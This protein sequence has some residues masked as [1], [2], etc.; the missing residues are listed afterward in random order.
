MPK[1]HRVLVRYRLPTSDQWSGLHW[2]DIERTESNEMRVRVASAVQGERM[3]R[4]DKFED[5]A[6]EHAKKL[7][8]I[9]FPGPDETPGGCPLR[10]RS[11]E[12][13]SYCLVFTAN[14]M[15]RIDFR[16]PLNICLPH[17]Q[18]WVEGR[19]FN[20]QNTISLSSCFTEAEIAHDKRLGMRI[21]AD[22]YDLLVYPSEL[23]LDLERQYRASDITAV[24]QH[25]EV[26]HKVQTAVVDPSHDQTNRYW[27][28]TERRE[29][30]AIDMASVESALESNDRMLLHDTVCRELTGVKNNCNSPEEY[31]LALYTLL[32]KD[33][34]STDFSEDLMG[35]IRL[36]RNTM[37]RSSMDL[38]RIFAQEGSTKPSLATVCQYVFA[39]V[40]QELKNQDSSLVSQ[41]SDD[42]ITRS[43]PDAYLNIYLGSSNEP[44]E[45]WQG[46]QS[47][48]STANDARYAAFLQLGELQQAQNHDRLNS[49]YSNSPVVV[50]AR[51]VS[52]GLESEQGGRQ[53]NS[54]SPNLAH[55]HPRLHSMSLFRSTR[56]QMPSEAPQVNRLLL[57]FIGAALCG[58]GFSLAFSSFFTG[59]AILAGGILCL[60]ASNLPTNHNPAAN[61]VAPSGGFGGYG[62]RLL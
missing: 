8:V 4:D 12:L 32:S 10:V 22:N 34:I 61:Y 36:F 52:V 6:P 9:D 21:S 49:A 33:E 13:E 20:P 47:G 37:L 38:N 48:I 31:Q 29:K 46:R 44:S 14:A 23:I 7:L 24:P 15:F 1:Y 45:V 5:L 19:L 3:P 41:S 35:A 50:G 28:T 56:G 59:A 60:L 18:R 55:L 27:L 11:S 39:C 53:S 17:G 57:R 51:D 43:R 30:V 40:F 42:Y 54:L 26:P 2:C 62:A 25:E 16:K 58:L